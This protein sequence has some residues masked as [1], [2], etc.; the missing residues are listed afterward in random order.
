MPD[1]LKKKLGDIRLYVQDEDSD[2]T[3][4]NSMTQRVKKGACPYSDADLEYQ[5]I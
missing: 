1:N 5:V 2:A 4:G 3:N